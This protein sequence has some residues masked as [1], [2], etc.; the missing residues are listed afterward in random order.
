[1]KSTQICVT[2]HQY[3]GDACDKCIEASRRQKNKSKGKGRE[4]K[5]LEKVSVDTQGPFSIKGIDGS[6]YNLKIVDSNSKYITT[7]LLPN[8][9]SD[10]TAKVMEHFMK[11]SERQTG[12]RLKNVATDG[13]TEFYGEFLDLLEGKGIKKNQ[14]SGL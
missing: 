10:T 8:K 3:Q 14:R 6:K 12:N 11:R 5:V 1:L 13:G 4:Y 2:G 7:V 9:S